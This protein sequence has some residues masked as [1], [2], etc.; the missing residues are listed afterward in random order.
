MRCAGYSP[1]FSL[2]V[3]M[4]GGLRSGLAVLHVQAMRSRWIGPHAMEVVCTAA[5]SSCAQRCALI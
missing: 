1:D 3:R 2:V 5:G 4:A